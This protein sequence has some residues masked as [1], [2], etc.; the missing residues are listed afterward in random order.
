M[1]ISRVSRLHVTIHFFSLLMQRETRNISCLHCHVR[2]VRTKNGW[3]KIFKRIP[4]TTCEI[5]MV[6]SESLSSF[7]FLL[8][9][10]L[11]VSSML[12]YRHKMKADFLPNTSRKRS[13]NGNLLC[14][15][16]VYLS[17]L[18]PGERHRMHLIKF[19]SCHHAFAPTK[20]ENGFLKALVSFKRSS[21]LVPSQKCSQA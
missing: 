12:V 13:H 2:K 21:L 6:F 19:A 16:C 3:R 5:F 1:Y 20:Y 8:L 17:C 7:H 9:Q 11:F 15:S 10:L 4:E 14:P 18:M